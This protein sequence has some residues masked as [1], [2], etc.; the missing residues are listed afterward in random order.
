MHEGVKSPSAA[1]VREPPLY[2]SQHVCSVNMV[3]TMSA[4]TSKW[5][6]LPWIEGTLLG[7]FLFL[8]LVLEHYW[9]LFTTRIVILV[10][11]ALSFDMVWGYVGIL[12]F[13]Q[14]LFFGGAGYGTALLATKLGFTSALILLPAAVLA[15]LLISFVMAAII[16]FGKRSPTAVFVALGTLT[17]SYV[18]ERL[19]RG[20]S[21]VGGQ[22]GIPSLPR[23]TIGT[24][25]IEE[26]IHFYYL[27]FGL[28]VLV[29]IGLRWAVRSQFGLVLAGI[30]EQEERLAFLGY[31][32]QTYKGIVFCLAGMIAGLSGGL[33]SFHEGFVGPAQLGPVFSTQVALYSM[34]GGA[35]T[36]IGAVIGTGSI[37]A[38]GYF[39][40][41]Y[42]ETGWPILLGTLLLAI[43]T[44]RPAGLISL[45]VSERERIGAFG[46]GAVS[47][48]DDIAERCHE[49]A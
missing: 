28:L 12:S 40:S 2:G 48:S 10:L 1:A 16:L 25:E 20:W 46:G 30:R 38:V 8:P 49:H 22:N 17:G 21:Y 44:Y 24:M 6:V 41:Q 42:W 9:V 14:A 29:Y 15:G 4:F 5:K 39:V 23:L 18:V 19:L 3:S 35:G 34:F 43:V 47:A 26:G 45:V 33:Y 37:E 27:A 36:L 7:L 32:T 11:L 13:G 31:Q